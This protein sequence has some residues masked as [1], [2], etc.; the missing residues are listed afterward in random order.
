MS[1]K[2]EYT[3]E[4]SKWRCGGHPN[5]LMELTSNCLGVGTTNLLNYEGYSCCL[6]QFAQQVLETPIPPGIAFPCTLACSIGMY[7][8]NFVEPNKLNTALA[9]ECVAINDNQATTVKQKIAL[10]TSLL[11]EHKITLHLTLNNQ[12]VKLEDLK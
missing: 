3:L 1:R 9:Y 4:L 8:E 7:D 6:G 10:L 5:L 2:T 11:A 12:P